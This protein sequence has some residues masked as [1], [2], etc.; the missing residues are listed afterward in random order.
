MVLTQAQWRLL[1]GEKIYVSAA[2]IPP[3]K[4]GSNRKYV[5][6]LPPRYNFAF[7]TGFEE[8]EKIIHAHP[9]HAPC[10]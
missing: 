7:P 8:V 9:L 4:L 3:G 2:P 10:G 6:L 5:F 1:E